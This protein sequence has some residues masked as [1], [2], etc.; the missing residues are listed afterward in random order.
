MTIKCCSPSSI[1]T[2]GGPQRQT[3]CVAL[4]SATMGT[5]EACGGR[6]L[7]S[8]GQRIRPECAVLRLGADVR[9]ALQRELP[10]KV[11]E[12]HPLAV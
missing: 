6:R 12:Q 4:R 10:G 11:A 5:R 1:A 7:P 8:Q 2:G 3:E 9:V